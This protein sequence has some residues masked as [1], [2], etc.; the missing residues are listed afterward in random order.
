MKRV[1]SSEMPF[2]IG[3][4]KNS[5]NIIM[6]KTRYAVNFNVLLLSHSKDAYEKIAPFDRIA[7]EI[8]K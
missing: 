3:L 1:S 5:D 8:L 6:F 7:L 4:V 2:Y